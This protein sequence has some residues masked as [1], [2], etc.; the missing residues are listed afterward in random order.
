MENDTGMTDAKTQLE[1]YLAQD[2]AS[3][4]LR[5][6]ESVRLR[7]LTTIAAIVMSGTTAAVIAIC[8]FMVHTTQAAYQAQFEMALQAKK[9]ICRL[10]S[11]HPE[12][13]LI[14]IGQESTSSQTDRQ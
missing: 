4:K 1:E 6:A 5:N 3:E 14:I 12:G 11:M 10:Q 2:L 7:R 13:A 9:E 8:A